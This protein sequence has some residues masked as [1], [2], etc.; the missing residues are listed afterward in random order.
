M[1]IKTERREKAGGSFADERRA[2]IDR[3]AL[4]YDWYIPERRVD[5]D[6]R[7]RR[8]TASGDGG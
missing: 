4:T 7:Q 2:G 3:R 6:R 8:K 1:L 5:T